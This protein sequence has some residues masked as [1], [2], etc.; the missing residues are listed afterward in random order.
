MFTLC[1][2]AGRKLSTLSK[3][4][5][6]TSFEKKENSKSTSGVTV[7]ILP[8]NLDGYSRNANSNIIIFM[9]EL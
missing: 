4:S 2:R 1:K 3:I 8:T 6:Y 7:W 9:K 5:N